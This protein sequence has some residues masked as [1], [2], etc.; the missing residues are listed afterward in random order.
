MYEMQGPDKKRGGVRR[1][2]NLCLVGPSMT[3]VRLRIDEE[4]LRVGSCLCGGWLAVTLEFM[5]WLDG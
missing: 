1:V 4:S 5:G 3:C 2:G